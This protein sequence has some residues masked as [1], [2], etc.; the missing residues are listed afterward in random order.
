MIRLV[1]VTPNS[2]SLELVNNDCYY[3]NEYEVYLNDKKI[4]SYNLNV[5][6]I[7]DL[8]P[9]TVY[10]VKVIQN[11]K[12]SDI[13]FKTLD[14]KEVLFKASNYDSNKDYTEELQNYI[15][16]LKEDEYLKIDGIYHVICLF[17]KS[18]TYI[19][20]PK[21]SK[22]IG[23]VDRTKYP[24]LPKD[25]LLN[26]YPIGTWEGNARTSFA[27]LITG[28]GAKNCMIYGE[29]IIDCNAS[30]SDWW[31]D[32]HTIRIACRPKG[33]FLHTCENV[34]LQG[35]TCC[36][37]PSWNQHCFFCKDIN[38]IDTFFQNPP[39]MP[40]T[41]GID[42]ESSD[43]VNIIGVKFSV[44]DDC[45]AIKSGRYAF[46][47]KYHTP[48]SNIVIRNCLM[49]EGH[50]GVTLGSENSGGINNVVVTNCYFKS[51]DRGLRIKSQRGRGNLAIIKDI[52]FD[53]IIMD[54]V[55][56]CFVINAYY[57]SGS[58]VL[59]WRYDEKYVEPSELTPKL[60]KFTFKNI[61][62]KDIHFGVG[63]FLG[64]P[65]SK[66]EEIELD[67]ISISYAKDAL[68]GEIAMTHRHE[69]HSKIGFYVEN[70]DKL[71]LKDIKFENQPSQMY[72]AKNCNIIEK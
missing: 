3:T 4:L 61:V 47:K 55:R 31:V 1:T 8:T 6:S 18:N 48:A 21:G 15:D 45:I 46:A 5:F 7:Y 33:I 67:N 13:E 50:G 72:I 66:I 57:M 40:T 11:K 52:T 14:K 62:C 71:T 60:G 23:E 34:T 42:P 44:G 64:L 25:V 70:V 10:K 22:L 65:E 28:L 43:G 32:F 20:L 35:I 53:N 2:V 56:A 19:Y 12:E 68:K 36:N 16:E 49:N 24:I 29:G 51:T 38:Y 9:N 26:G 37:T 30:N 39:L 59:D 27:S 58:D 69:Q 54:N 41:D 17:L 63:Y